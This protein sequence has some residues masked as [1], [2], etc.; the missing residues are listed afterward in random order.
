[1]YNIFDL[2][3]EGDIIKDISYTSQVDEFRVDEFP[4]SDGYTAA[5][6]Q[7]AAETR[8]LTE[9]EEFRQKIIRNDHQMIKY[10]I[11]KFLNE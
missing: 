5:K 3:S 1:M 9:E 2:N 7:L 10:Y 8:S 4:V 6:A 11:N